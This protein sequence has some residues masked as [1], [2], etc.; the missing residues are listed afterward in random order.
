MTDFVFD[1]STK[2]AT[3]MSLRRY[4][5]N[6]QFYSDKE[7]ADLSRIAAGTNH[8][9]KINGTSM[10]SILPDVHL[11]PVPKD[12]RLRP[13]DG[14]G[15]IKLTPAQFALRANINNVRS[16]HAILPNSP[17]NPGGNFS[18]LANPSWACYGIYVPSTSRTTLASFP[19]VLKSDTENLPNL[20]ATVNVCFVYNQAGKPS[21]ML[22]RIYGDFN[23]DI[24]RLVEYFT[25]QLGLNVY[26]HQSWR[27]HGSYTQYNHPNK[28][29]NVSTVP[30]FSLPMTAQVLYAT[31]KTKTLVARYNDIAA[32]RKFVSGDML[33]AES[34]LGALLATPNGSIKTPLILPK[35][36]TDFLKQFVDGMKL[37]E[38][39]VPTVK[40]AVCIKCKTSFNTNR[41]G[42]DAYLA[43]H[44]VACSPACL[45]SY[46]ALHKIKTRLVT[47]ER[48]VFAPISVTIPAPKPK[49][50]EPKK[51]KKVATPTSGSNTYRTANLNGTNA[52]AANTGVFEWNRVARVAGHMELSLSELEAQIG[53]QYLAEM[54]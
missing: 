36:D 41:I 5:I 38:G 23:I 27:S 51:L 25:Y 4:G 9:I 28:N 20:V 10:F 22:S 14:I 40:H 49:V 16:C 26:V 12:Q 21:V 2:Q 32:P 19:H 42:D 15:F 53:A 29:L 3:A 47:R 13:A 1:F 45:E 48:N 34:M 33:I 24:T 11:E 18:Y 52:Q 37:V 39:R 17:H 35:E 6:P 43:G 46:I 7:V 44:G 30:V 54:A 31:A 50:V 8:N